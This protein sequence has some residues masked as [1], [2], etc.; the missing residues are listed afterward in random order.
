MKFTSF[1][2]L[3]AIAANPFQSGFAQAPTSVDA[4]P[5]R[6]VQSQP[7]PVSPEILSDRR[8]VFRLV[9][10]KV[11]EV[12]ITGEFTATPLVMKK[13]ERGEWS[14][15]TAPI[16]PEEYYYN[17]LIDG[18]RT[19]DPSN[20]QIKMGSTPSTIQS[21]LHI[22]GEETAFF[23]PQAGPHGV[24]HECLYPS[25]SLDGIRRAL[26]YTPPDYNQSSSKRYAV[27][28][29]LHGANGDENVWLRQ[30]RANVILD[31]L[32]AAGKTSPFI[33]VMPF[34]YGESPMTRA[35]AGSNGSR[36]GM[37]RN[38][39]L[40]GRDLLEDLIPYVESA[41]RVHTDKTHRSLAGLL[42]E[43]A[44]PPPI[45]SPASEIGRAHV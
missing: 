44:S 3:L 4:G 22:P 19:L 33:V 20:P 7:P 38:T 12:T 31:N 21:V 37:S 8:V 42:M 28:Y 18:V 35:P 27:L 24:V 30:G 23:E 16:A 6:P 41:F 15:T 25:K 13:D 10:S 34:G 43:S 1:T 39:E 32:L 9:A 29:L 5:A 11:N 36:T 45:D 26:V 17:F 14:V 2:L 40:F